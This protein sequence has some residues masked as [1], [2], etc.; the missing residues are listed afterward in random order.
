MTKAITE[1]E[2]CMAERGV[3]PELVGCKAERNQNFDRFGFPLKLGVK[4]RN[5]GPWKLLAC[6]QPIVMHTSISYAL[7]YI[8]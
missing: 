4:E 2:S 6:G 1:E 5:I 3:H 8:P 7:C